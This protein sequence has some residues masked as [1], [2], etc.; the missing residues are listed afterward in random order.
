VQAS[1]GWR[2]PYRR[3]SIE[4]RERDRNQIEAAT[5]SNG[6]KKVKRA[7]RFCESHVMII[8]DMRLWPPPTLYVVKHF[9]CT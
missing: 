2:S 6:N 3:R 5:R 4:R 7:L 9:D 8:A 1:P